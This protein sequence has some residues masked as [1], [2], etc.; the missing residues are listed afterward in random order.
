[1]L[2]QVLEIPPISCRS[3]IFDNFFFLPILQELRH[4]S[5]VKHV[6]STSVE[7][8]I[9]YK[10]I[11]YEREKKVAETEIIKRIGYILYIYC[12]KRYYITLYL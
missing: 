4:Q 10:I 6:A 9:K 7:I 5:I 12:I 2:T 3:T 8:Y 11:K 1:M